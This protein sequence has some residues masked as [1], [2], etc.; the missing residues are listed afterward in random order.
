MK[1]DDA[2]GGGRANWVLVVD[3]DIDIL[4]YLA[5][6]FRYRGH[7]VRA[8]TDG[9]M[10]LSLIAK[11]GA[12]GLIVTDLQMPRMHG[13]ELVERLRR[14]AATAETPIVVFSGAPVPV[15]GATAVLSKLEGEKLMS[16]ASVICAQDKAS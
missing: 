3:D 11:Y 8:A 12:P 2:T 16:Y 10:A 5:M 4:E 1:R 7:E 6:L 14:Q 15:S 9:E 13:L